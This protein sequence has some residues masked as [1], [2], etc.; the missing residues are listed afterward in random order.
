MVASVA[1][2]FRYI[3]ISIAGGRRVISKSRKLIPLFSPSVGLNSK[4]LLMM[5]K[6]RPMHVE[7]PE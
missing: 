2:G 3:S 5:G 1:V 4:L 6:E 7:V